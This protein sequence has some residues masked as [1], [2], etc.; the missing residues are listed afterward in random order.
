MKGFNLGVNVLALLR[1]LIGDV[2]QL[3]RHDLADGA[4]RHGTAIP[5][6]PRQQRRSAFFGILLVDDPKH[7]D[8]K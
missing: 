5:S 8:Q 1:K 4:R 6:R 7:V 3:A 2:H